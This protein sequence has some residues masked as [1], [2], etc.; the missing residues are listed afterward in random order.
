MRPILVLSYGFWQRNFGGDPSI[1]GQ[2]FE[3]NDRPHTVV[4]V[5]PPIPQYP[6][7]NDVYMPTSACPFRSGQ[8][9]IESRTMRMMRVF[10]RLK[11]DAPLNLE[12]VS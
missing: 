2:V 7:D 10:G 8:H 5:L 6:D 11:A 4:G 9:M 1:V 12:V 3:M